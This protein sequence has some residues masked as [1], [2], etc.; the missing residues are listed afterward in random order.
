MFSVYTHY[1]LVFVMYNIYSTRPQWGQNL[2]F[3]I[4]SLLFLAHFVQ[5]Y[6]FL[7]LKNGII[8]KNIIYQ[9]FR[10]PKLAIEILFYNLLWA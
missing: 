6:N 1:I 5:L 9:C 3:I 2:E 10:E 7:R 8:L 4:V